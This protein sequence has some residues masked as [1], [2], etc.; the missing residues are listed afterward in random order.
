MNKNLGFVATIIVIAIVLFFASQ[1]IDLNQAMQ[2][3][4]KANVALLAVALALETISIGLKT[5]KWKTLLSEINNSVSFTELFKIQSLGLAISNITPAR[6]GEA[7]KAFYLEKHGVKKRITLLT[8]LWEHLFDVIAILAFTTFVA[9]GYGTILFVF[10]VLAIFLV[11]LAYNIDLVVKKL[12][13]FKQLT[14]LSEFTL[15]KFKKKTLFK[16]LAI[17]LAAWLV[18][19][20]AV[21]FAFNA[22]GINLA[23]TQ[24]IGSYAVAIIIGLVSTV[25]GGLGSLD[26][27]LFLLLK[28]SSPAATLAAAIIAAR[29]V[30]IGWIYLLGS[31]SALLLHREKNF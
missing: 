21:S 9:S 26:A 15:H 2:V 3:L 24:V 14:F 12:S 19:L 27:T 16:A 31:I 5:L 30:T 29:I 8:I 25:P 11:I 23:Y 7:T 28:E 22:V 6:V 13:R 17:A 20:T 10:L 4:T 18:E 1:Y